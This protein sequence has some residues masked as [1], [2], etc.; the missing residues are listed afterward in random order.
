MPTTKPDP[1]RTRSQIAAY[2]AELPP[3]SRRVAKA[4]RATIQAAAPKAVEHFSYGIPGFRLDGKPLLWYAG[5][6]THTSVYPVTP[7]MKSA[8]GTQIKPY[9]ASKG[10]LKFPLAEDLPLPLV[11]KLVKTRA[12]E[13]RSAQ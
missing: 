6:K 9:Q 11:T 7:A 5:W 13:I 12:R 4:L 10:T 8:H 2:L 1:R 3:D